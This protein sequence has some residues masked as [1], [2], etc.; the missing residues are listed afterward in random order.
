VPRYQRLFLVAYAPGR[1]SGGHLSCMS[2][3]APH[4]VLRWSQ[5]IAPARPA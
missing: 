3:L 2:R 5:R 1:S 4:T